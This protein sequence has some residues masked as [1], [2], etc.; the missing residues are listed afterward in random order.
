MAEKLRV[1]VSGL[2]VSPSA[3][4]RC[5]LQAARLPTQQLWAMLRGSSDLISRLHTFD[6]YS[7]FG[8]PCSA[9]FHRGEDLAHLTASLRRALECS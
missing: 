7:A 3:A 8:V 5:I 4:F 2:I 6:L 1:L 9:A